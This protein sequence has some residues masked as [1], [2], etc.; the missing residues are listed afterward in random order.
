VVA[1][2]AFVLIE[3]LL[4][5]RFT[6]A[7]YEN[8]AYL[9]PPDLVQ[10]KDLQRFWQSLSPRQ[11]TNVGDLQNAHPIARDLQTH[12]WD[13]TIRLARQMHARS[14]RTGNFVILGSSFSNPWAELFPVDDS[15]FP[16]GRISQARPARSHFEPSIETRRTSHL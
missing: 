5:R 7:E 16:T 15:N 3:V 14:F 9:N 1:D 11:I 12:G 13:A 8:L 10:K 2:D 4:D 6:L